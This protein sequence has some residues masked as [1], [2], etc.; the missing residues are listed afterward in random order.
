MKGIIF[1]EP[2]FHKVVNGEKT[3][4]RRIIKPQPRIN[5]FFE[6]IGSWTEIAPGR[7]EA[8]KPRYKKGETL[9]L[10]EPYRVSP[11][12]KVSYKHSPAGWQSPDPRW[13]NEF[14]MPDKYARFF[15]EI[16]AVRCERLQ[17]I[18]DEDCMREGIVK[19]RIAKTRHP[20]TV[21]ETDYIDF[22][23]HDPPCF[24][25]CPKD[26]YADLIDKIYGKGTW[27]SNPY[28]WVYDFKLKKI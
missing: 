18:S 15:I 8:F 14:F 24:W 17:D 19:K 28:V 4:T 13:I 27:E 3:Q 23:T 1:S 6:S 21:H 22:Y 25:E 7:Y 10:K 5:L 9:Y 11:N 12:D 26:A 2:M 16:T 20:S